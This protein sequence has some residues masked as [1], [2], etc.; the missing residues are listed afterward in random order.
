MPRKE[1]IEKTNLEEELLVLMITDTEERECFETEY[2]DQDQPDNKRV[3]NQSDTNGWKTQLS[4][5][6]EVLEALANG[7]TCTQIV[8]AIGL[9]R[10]TST[11]E[12]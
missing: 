12:I 1:R 7:R 10:S 9:T 3:G 5:L 4:T 11:F 2:F 8:L 6:R